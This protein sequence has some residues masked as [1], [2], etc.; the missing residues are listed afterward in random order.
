M[1]FVLRNL[2]DMPVPSFAYTDRNDGRVFVIQIEDGVKHKKTI[3]HMT[4]S[5]P[6]KQ[7]M[8]PNSYF[9][10]KYQNLFGSLELD[11]YRVDTP[12]KV[13][14]PKKAYIKTA[15]SLEKNMIKNRINN[16]NK[17]PISPVYCKNL[18]LYNSFH[19]KKQKSL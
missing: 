18:N 3:G 12:K 2:P 7:R 9:Q 5:T 16:R 10:E 14:T 1:G 19:Y 13:Y 15:K 11:S 6:G 4:D 8:V 17:I